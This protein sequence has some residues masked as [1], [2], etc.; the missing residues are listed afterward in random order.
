MSSPLLLQHLLQ[1]ET[2]DGNL[3]LSLV[4]SA[5]NNDGQLWEVFREEKCAT[6]GVRSPHHPPQLVLADWPVSFPASVEPLLIR[7]STS[8]LGPTAHAPHPALQQ[9]TNVSVVMCCPDK[10]QTE[11]FLHNILVD[12]SLSLLIYYSSPS[13]SIIKTI[14]AMEYIL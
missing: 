4:I 1:L 2:F 10:V 14:N 5:A 6:P 3:S 11:V 8:Q 9:T 7:I 13:K 12:L